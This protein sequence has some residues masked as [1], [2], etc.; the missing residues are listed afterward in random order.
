MFRIVK[1]RR[2]V[3]FPLVYAGMHDQ[4]D[5]DNKTN[6]FPNFRRVSTIRRGMA[7]LP[8]PPGHGATGY[9]IE[10]VKFDVAP[11][12]IFEACVYIMLYI[13]IRSSI[14]LHASGL[15]WAYY[16]MSIDKCI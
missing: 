16:P 7:P 6:K 9:S 8:P 5:S 14:F 13:Y 11:M 10:T 3:K 12:R 15:Y 2:E 1:Q 4:Q